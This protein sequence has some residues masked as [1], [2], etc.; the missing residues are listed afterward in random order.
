M[1]NIVCESPEH[2]RD[3]IGRINELSYLIPCV[4]EGANHGR[5]G[6][7]F[8]RKKRKDMKFIHGAGTWIRGVGCVTSLAAGIPF[9]DAP[10]EPSQVLRRISC[11]LKNVR[12]YRTSERTPQ[13]SVFLSIF[14]FNPEQ[15]AI[16]SMANFAF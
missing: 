3:K 7:G 13:I 6:G 2:A 11:G 10:R 15:V 16:Y 9:L 14:I 5:E 4:R 8:G 12:S 1:G